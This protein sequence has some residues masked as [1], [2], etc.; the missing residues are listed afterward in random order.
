MCCYLQKKK[1]NGVEWDLLDKSNLE[2]IQHALDNLAGNE[3]EVSVH[4]HTFFTLQTDSKRHH[5]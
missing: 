2:D 1:L 3:W 5:R 4:D